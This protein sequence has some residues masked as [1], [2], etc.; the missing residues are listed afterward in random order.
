MAHER[1]YAV[2]VDSAHRYLVR[3]VSLHEISS[4]DELERAARARMM[5][6]AVWGFLWSKVNR[7]LWQGRDHVQGDL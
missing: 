4:A 6:E 2:H 1:C 3:M 7:I 5:G